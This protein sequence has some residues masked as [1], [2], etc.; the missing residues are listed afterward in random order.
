MLEA[1]T[2]Q[3]FINHLAMTFSFPLRSVAF[4]FFYYSTRSHTQKVVSL[5]EAYFIRAPM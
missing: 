1:D 5:S 3:N 4:I 2:R